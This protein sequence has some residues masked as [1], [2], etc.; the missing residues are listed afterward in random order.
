MGPIRQLLASRLPTLFVLVV[1]AAVAVAAYGH[2]G[3]GP[4][5]ASSDEETSCGPTTDSPVGP[6]SKTEQ[7]GCRVPE[8]SGQHVTRKQPNEADRKPPVREAAP[9]TISG[10]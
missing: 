1:A 7:F 8:G 5:R 2:P 6:R 9:R 4:A 10:K 3:S